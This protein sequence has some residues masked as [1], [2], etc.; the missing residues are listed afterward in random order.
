MLNKALLVTLTLGS[1]FHPSS[2]PVVG[3]AT[4]LSVCVVLYSAVQSGPVQVHH[5]PRTAT[6]TQCCQDQ[7]QLDTT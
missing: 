1:N 6:G 2:L 3:R 4:D 7:S 5:Q